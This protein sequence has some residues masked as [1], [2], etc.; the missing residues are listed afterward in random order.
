LDNAIEFWLL[1]FG[2]GVFQGGIQFLSR[3][4]FTKLIP[5]EKASEYFGIYD[6]FGKGAAFLGTMIMGV[7][8]QIFQTLKAGIVVLALMFIIGFMLIN[9]KIKSI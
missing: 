9:K 6:I 2:V 4:Y 3:S 8:T 5:K 7:S 1:A